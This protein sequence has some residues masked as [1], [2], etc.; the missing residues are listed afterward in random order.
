MRFPL[1]LAV[2]VATASLLV[3]A[4]RDENTPHAPL[5]PMPRVGGTFRFALTEPSGLDPAS[6]EDTYQGL[7]VGQLFEGL[8]ELDS[9]LNVVPAL[10]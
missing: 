9:H 4:C 7:L 5:S 8:V 6:S 1:S 3:A 10:A 2:T